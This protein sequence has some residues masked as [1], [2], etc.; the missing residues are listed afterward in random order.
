LFL[1]SASIEFI[2]LFDA[3]TCSWARDERRKLPLRGMQGMDEMPF[4][5]RAMAWGLALKGKG[6]LMK[7]LHFP[8]AVLSA[9]C[10]FGCLVSLVDFRS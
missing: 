6:S 9:L 10:M 5:V 8:W 7:C 3:S 1:T 2:S 4:L